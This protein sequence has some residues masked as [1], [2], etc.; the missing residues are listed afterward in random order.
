MATINFPRQF[1]KLRAPKI[2]EHTK[3]MLATAAVAY[4]ERLGSPKGEHARRPQAGRVQLDVGEVAIRAGY[5][6]GLNEIAYD[7][8]LNSE[9]RRV[10]DI[11]EEV[12]A[13]KATREFITNYKEL[14][15]GRLPLF[16]TPDITEPIPPVTTDQQSKY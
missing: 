3:R 7:P 6:R 9:Q 2:G 13:E 4:S 1:E 12:E 16:G 10:P 14:H 15:G 8:T 5:A 11:A